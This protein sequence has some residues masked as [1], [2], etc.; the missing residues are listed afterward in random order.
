MGAIKRGFANNI[1]T[2]GA[3]QATGLTGSVP[4]G[5]LGNSGQVLIYT[6]TLSGTATSH[7]FVHGTNG[8]VFDSTYPIYRFYFYD[9]NAEGA[10]N[11]FFIRVRTGAG[12]FASSSYLHTGF[13]VNYTG[14]GTS[15]AIQGS[16]GAFQITNGAPNY[17]DSTA[18]TF[19]GWIEFYRP[20][21]TRKHVTNGM[22]AQHADDGYADAFY[23]GGNYNSD[24]TLTGFRLLASNNIHGKVALYGLN[25]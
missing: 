5:S 22:S 19:S 13:G 16:T 14:G 6:E 4:A 21:Q 25:G 10:G 3:F 8:F 17:S 18:D 7:D 9:M 15:S 11:T 1:T 20:D 24:Q 2:S 12:T 23:W